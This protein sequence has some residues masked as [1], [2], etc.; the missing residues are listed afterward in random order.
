MAFGISV[1]PGLDNTTEENVALIRQATELGITRLFTSLHIPE[2]DD[3]AFTDGLHAILDAALN[4]HLDL[5]ADVTPESADILSL[6]S[7]TPEAFYEFGIHTLRLDDGYVIRPV[8]VEVV[9]TRPNNTHLLKFVL[10]EGRKRQIRKMCSAAHLVVL[11][12][13]RVKV[14]GFAL[15]DDLKPGAWRD[16]T[17][18]EVASLRA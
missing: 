4:A 18:D 13:K 11:A 6:S 9:E 16:L 8:P 3:T 10:S 14:G 1:Y 2:H 7:C 17:A 5:I 12:L 15:P